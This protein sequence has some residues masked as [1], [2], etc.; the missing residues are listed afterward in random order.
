M[1]LIPSI[2]RKV[3][4]MPLAQ[5]QK[6]REAWDSTAYFQIS[7]SICG[8]GIRIRDWCYC[9]FGPTVKHGNAEYG[10]QYEGFALYSIAGDPAEMVNMVAR[11]EYKHIADQLRD[12]L[13]KRMV[14]AG[15]PETT[16]T[17]IHYYA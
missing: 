3:R 7:Q 6:A 5:G 13:Q 4:I 12:E 17:P 8:R 10:K 2:I 11:P 15:E 16:I 1:T 9:A 14:A